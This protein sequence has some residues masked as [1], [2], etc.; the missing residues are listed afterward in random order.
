[1]STRTERPKIQ[2]V[3][4]G[5]PAH[6]EMLFDT[7]KE[8]T[9]KYGPWWAFTFRLLAPYPAEGGG[10]IAAG[11]EVVYFVRSP[12]V[13]EQLKAYRRGDRFTIAMTQALGQRFPVTEV[14]AYGTGPYAPSGTTPAGPPPAF[15]EEDDDIF[16]D[17]PLDEQP[18]YPDKEARAVQAP[19]EV[20]AIDSALGMEDFVTTYSQAIADAYF[21]LRRGIELISKQDPDIADDFIDEINLAMVKEIATTAL[22]ERGRERRTQQITRE[23]RGR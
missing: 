9:N 16:G 5:P 21:A 1:M 14:W 20:E 13:A 19:Q 6:G 15:A 2:L 10:V 3:V 11:E 18:I 4:N 12:Q 17:V 8:G 22:I 7:P 23:R